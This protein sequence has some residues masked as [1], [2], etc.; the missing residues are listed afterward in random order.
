MTSPENTS[1]YL[2]LHVRA[3]I[4][5]TVLAVVF[6]WPLPL[7]MA[8]HFTGSP[9]GDT[10]VYV[11]NQWVFRHELLAGHVNPYFTDRI[12]ALTGP[13]NLG[14]EQIRLHTFS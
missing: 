9:E 13:A 5:Y 8:T 1:A 11:W 2:R 10:G 6:T 4:A 3:L 12:F 14:P 7:H